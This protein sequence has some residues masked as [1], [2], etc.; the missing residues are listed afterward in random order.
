MDIDY[1]KL[2]QG[3]VL[4]REWS[5][6]I[7]GRRKL[8]KFLSVLLN[9]KKIGVTPEQYDAIQAIPAED[10][11]VIMTSRDV[12]T[13]IVLQFENMT[14]KIA[15]KIA[16]KVGRTNKADVS[17]L[18]SEAMVG[19]LKAA[20]GYTNLKVQF[21]TYAYR[22]AYNEVSRYMQRSYGSTLSGANNSLLWKYENKRVELCHDSKPHTFDDVCEALNLTNRQR[23][24]LIKTINS[25]VVSESELE[26]NLASTLMDNKSNRKVDAELIERMEQVA[27]SEIEKFA[28]ISQEEIRDLFPDAFSSL[29]EAADHC[30]FTSQAATEALRRARK[31]IAFAV[32]EE[33]NPHKKQ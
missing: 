11:C 25:G 17:Q 10:V 18:E 30:G 8:G 19:L 32:G 1:K 5:R 12:V 15:R 4:A 28:F 14:R 33:W 16:S 3:N 13:Q 27:L 6:K 26:H 23:H 24:R 22:A 9:K 7:L 21:F 31:K 2:A 29:R 20:R